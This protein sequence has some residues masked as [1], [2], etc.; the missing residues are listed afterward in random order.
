MRD[1]LKLM[2]IPFS[3]Y[4]MPVFWFA[5]SAAENFSVINAVWVFIIIH[6]FVY[7]ASNGYNCYFDRDEG[8]IGGLKNPPRVN[9]E[10]FWLVVI[11]D[12][13]AVI[14]AH[15]YSDSRSSKWCLG[16]RTQ[17]AILLS[18]K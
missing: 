6:F 8:S 1:A 18:F 12:L 14:G 3:V 7:P 2:R 11:F 9:K 5:L 10:L 13:I 16:R 17:K 4:L 15:W